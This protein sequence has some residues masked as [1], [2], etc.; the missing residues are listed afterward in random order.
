MNIYVEDKYIRLLKRNGIDPASFARQAF[1]SAMEDAEL[2]DVEYETRE[3]P[4]DPKLCPECG[5]STDWYGSCWEDATICSY[6]KIQWPADR[7]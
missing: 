4:I 5:Q 1:L 6:C 7:I 3:E 2:N